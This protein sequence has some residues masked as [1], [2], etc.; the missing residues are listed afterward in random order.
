MSDTPKTKNKMHKQVIL[1]TIGS[2]GIAATTLVLLL[3]IFRADISVSAPALII[4]I[5]G[6]VM[7]FIGGL[8]ISDALGR[9]GSHKLLH[10]KLGTVIQSLGLG[11]TVFALIVK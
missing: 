6:T 11:F 9:W 5:I 3:F 1:T 7:I 8:L 2:I 10:Y 4:G